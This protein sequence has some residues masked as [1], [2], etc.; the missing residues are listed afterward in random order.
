MIKWLDRTLIQ[1]PVHIALCTDEKS[2]HKE[3]KRLGLPREP[4]ICGEYANATTSKYEHK[5]TGKLCAIVTIKPQKHWHRAGI[6]A[7]LVHEAVHIWQWIK[8]I[9]GEHDPSKEFEAYSIQ[10]ISQ[11]LIEAYHDK[12][13]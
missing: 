3:L 13:K 8:E 6:D 12:K 4:Y 11:Y 10:A 2:F 7:L 9:L 5:P 1:S